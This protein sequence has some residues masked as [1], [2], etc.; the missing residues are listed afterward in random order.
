MTIQSFI[1]NAIEGGWRPKAGDGFVYKKCLFFSLARGGSAVHFTDMPQRNVKQDFVNVP[2]ERILL[3]P[4]AWKAIGKVEGWGITEGKCN[5][6]GHDARGR[7]WLLSS[8]V[9]C[10]ECR[11]SR[12]EYTNYMHRMIDHLIEDGTIESY[13]ETL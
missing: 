9:Q 12:A 2:T 1:E 13:L 10:P 11:T 8:P 6:C 5:G 7:G 3:D 4:E